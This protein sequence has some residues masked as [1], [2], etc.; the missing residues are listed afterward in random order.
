MYPTSIPD[1]EHKYNL[2]KMIMEKLEIDLME[3]K[4]AVQEATN[5]YDKTMSQYLHAQADFMKSL[6]NLNEAREAKSE[7]DE[8]F[9][10]A[11]DCCVSL[12]NN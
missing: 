11:I 10:S 3:S 4:K 2:R 5:K 9:K 7:F 1:L 8:T 6:T 12:K